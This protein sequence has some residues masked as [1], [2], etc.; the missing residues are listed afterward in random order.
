[1]FIDALGVP[2][3]SLTKGSHYPNQ[4]FS[5]EGSTER[6]LT[7]WWGATLCPPELNDIALAETVVCE[8]RM[9]AHREMAE[10][11]ERMQPTL[12]N[13]LE[14]QGQ[15]MAPAPET[16]LRENAAIYESTYEGAPSVLS[17]I[18]P[19]LLTLIRT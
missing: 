12:K 14:Y 17:M 1:M 7:Y 9:A 13:I 3:D 5:P 2:E 4:P 19:L 6:T 18:I 15:R 11:E 10:N 8:M 16:T